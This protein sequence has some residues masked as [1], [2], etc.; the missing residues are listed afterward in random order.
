MF[1]ISRFHLQIVL[2]QKR[3]DLLVHKTEEIHVALRA[4]CSTVLNQEMAQDGLELV[5]L[6]NKRNLEENEI[7]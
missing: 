7:S 1:I 4:I 5:A 2:A 6:T 3:S